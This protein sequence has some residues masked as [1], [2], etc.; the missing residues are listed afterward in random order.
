MSFEIAS[1][2]LWRHAKDRLNPNLGAVELALRLSPHV[3][4]LD[5]ALPEMN[6]LEALRVASRKRGGES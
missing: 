6:G 2:G 5:L 4:I 1:R 3:A